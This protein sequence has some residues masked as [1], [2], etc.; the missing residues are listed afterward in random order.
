MEN[1]FFDLKDLRHLGKNVIIGKTVRIRYPKEVL[2]GDNSIIDDFTYISTALE[3]GNFTHIATGCAIIGGRKAKITIGDFVNIAPSCQIVAGSNDYKGGDLVGPAIPEGYCGKA[4]IEDVT[5][6]NHCLLGCQTVV[7]PGVNMPEGMAT[8][9]FSLVKKS[10]YEGWA[11]YVGIP[12]KKLCDRERKDI[13]SG[14]KKLQEE[15]K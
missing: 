7:L 10:E 11:V 15:Y 6:D 5:I 9:A 3:L 8:G 4:D 14:S 13:I 2:I 12:C 1:I